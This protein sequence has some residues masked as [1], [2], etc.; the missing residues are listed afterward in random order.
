MSLRRE[1]LYYYQVQAQV[2]I[3]DVEFGDFV[4]WTEDGIAVERIIRDCAFYEEALNNIEHVYVY[5]ILPEIIGKWY[6]RTPIADSAGIVL[7]PDHKT[8]ENGGQEDYSD[9]DEDSEKPWCYCEQPKLWK[10]DS[11]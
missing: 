3:C 8:E 6:T 7:P 5:G 9:D 2:N 10:H 4:L 11:L 1:H